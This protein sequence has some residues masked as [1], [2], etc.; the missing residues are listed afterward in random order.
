MP[1]DSTARRAG[2]GHQPASRPLHDVEAATPAAEEARLLAWLQ[3]ESGRTGLLT[4]R[5]LKELHIEACAEMGL[6]PGSWHAFGREF[7]RLIGARKE[8]RWLS[9]EWLCGYRVPP[10]RLLGG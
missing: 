5:E 8:Y 9:G 6:Q 2:D 1:N 10:A 3:G 7:R 4:V